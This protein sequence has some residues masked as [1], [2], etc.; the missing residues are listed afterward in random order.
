MTEILEEEKDYSH[1]H[2]SGTGESFVEYSF[3]INNTLNQS[4]NMANPFKP[5]L[6]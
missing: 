2:Q 4:I 6:Q 5:H 1:N 3:D